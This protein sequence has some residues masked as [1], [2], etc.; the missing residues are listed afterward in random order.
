[1]H[2]TF[3]WKALLD[4]ADRAGYAKGKFGLRMGFG[5]KPA[6]LVVDMTNL[7]VDPKYPNANG[8]TGVGAIAAF[9][10]LIAVARETDTPIFYSRR[11]A[12]TKQVQQGV[13]SLKWGCTTDPLWLDDPEADEWPT[14]IQPRNNELEH[15]IEKSKPS[16]FFE[17]PLRTQLAYLGVDTLIVG[18]V[19]TSGCVRAAVTD[20]F[21]C[22]LRVIVPQ[23]CCADRSGISHAVSLIDMD[24]KFADVMP[25]SDVIAQMR[26]ISPTLANTAP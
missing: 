23:E 13:T 8:D 4:E 15:I 2:E 17:T 19:S 5:K 18:G 10:E 7:F 24:M 20:A 12:R 16:A 9:T 21:S 6:I 14:A 1:M 25:L 3:D 26:R 22:N 11:D